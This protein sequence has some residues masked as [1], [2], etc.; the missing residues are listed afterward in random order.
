M[1]NLWIAD[2][3]VGHRNFVR[4]SE[5]VNVWNVW[6]LFNLFPCRWPRD[7]QNFFP[8]F[9]KPDQKFV[10]VHHTLASDF[11]A[12]VFVYARHFQF[13]THVLYISSLFDTISAAVWLF[14]TWNFSASTRTQ[15]HDVS[16][17]STEVENFNFFAQWPTLTHSRR[18]TNRLTRHTRNTGGQDIDIFVTIVVGCCDFILS[19]EFIVVKP[20]ASAFRCRRYVI[21]FQYRWPSIRRVRCSEVSPLKSSEHVPVSSQKNV[22]YLGSFTVYTVFVQTYNVFRFVCFPVTIVKTLKLISPSLLKLYTSIH[23]CAALC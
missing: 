17:V 6:N 5:G 18:R 2:T 23:I 4:C 13:S 9:A 14:P 8:N 19:D 3:L 12:F 11:L 21:I 20:D 22:R 1:W 16:V 15:E 7:G 10:V